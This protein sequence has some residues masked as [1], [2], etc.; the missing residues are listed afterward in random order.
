MV[1]FFNKAM[2]APWEGETSIYAYIQKQIKDE[3]R[4]INTSLPD[5][6]EYWAGSKMRWVAGGMDGAMGHHAARG[7]LT[8]ELR[9]LVHQLAKQ[10]RKPRRSLR[11]AI[12]R[13]LIKAD[14]GGKIDA[15]LEELRKHPGVNPEHVFSEGKWLAENGA[16]RNV[17]KFGIALLGLFQ[18]E[19]VKELLLTLGK[20]EEFTLYATVAIQ[21]GMEDENNVLFELVKD[22]NGWGK[23]HIVERLE[24]STPEIKQWL[25]R[26]G[27]QNSVMNEYLACICARNGELHAALSSEQVDSELYEGA[28]DIIQALLNGGPAED[29][30]DYEH[31]PQVISNYLRLSYTMC[32]A[33]KP[34]SVILEIRD[35]LSHT[36]EM[37]EKRMSLGWTE[38]LRME[39][40]AASQR[41]ITLSKWESLVIDAVNST[42][43]VD[44]Y[45]GVVCAKKLGI[46]S[47]DALYTQLLTNPLQE[48]FYYDLMKTDDLQRIEKLVQLAEDHLPLQEIATGPKDEMG[49]GQEYVPHR[50]L[51]GIL[52]R[53]DEYEGMGKRL[54]AVGLNSP[55]TSNRNMAL[56]ALEAW[57][58]SSWGNE[59][60]IAL[61]K[62]AEI[63]PNESV[64][65][66]VLRL[67]EVKYSL[68]TLEE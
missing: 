5:D 40:L 51:L 3:G 31:A 22:V 61:N 8:D 67:K 4:L 25:L 13:K 64:R 34:L 68:F 57:E 14:I 52:Q 26:K 2:R 60:V 65:E 32:N 49:L 28:T 33:L 47:W 53:L 20:H 54:L 43:R 44:R 39:I 11:K 37:W 56:K 6:E 62:L 55:V 46:D 38:E 30:D 9:E 50:C 29:I 35:L 23:I 1:I 21:N 15:V 19:H 10:S 63:E 41:I 66:R 58:A 45:Y 42:D 18:N 24:P 59:L 48:S 12:Y 17:V 7:N 16:H 27:C 36:D